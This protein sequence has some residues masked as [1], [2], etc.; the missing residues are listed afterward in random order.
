MINDKWKM[1]LYS[2][3]Y[4]CT[5]ITLCDCFQTWRFQKRKKETHLSLRYSSSTIYID[6]FAIAVILTTSESMLLMVIGNWAE[7]S[8]RPD[9]VC[10]H[11][12]RHQPLFI[13]ISLS[14]AHQ[15]WQSRSHSNLLHVK[16]TILRDYNNSSR[17]SPVKAKKNADNS[18]RRMRMDAFDVVDNSFHGSVKFKTQKMV[19]I[20]TDGNKNT[21]IQQD[22]ISVT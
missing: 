19:T 8:A 2:E 10:K 4:S 21:L 20:T 7:V 18:M 22:P 5:A 11:H 9:T 14:P 15:Q 13:L 1:I 16:P 12:R 6:N 17:I 3:I